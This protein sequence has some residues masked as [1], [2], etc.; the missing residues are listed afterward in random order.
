MF[1]WQNSNKSEKTG[2]SI[3]KGGRSSPSCIALKSVFLENVIRFVCIIADAQYGVSP[4]ALDDRFVQLVYLALIVG[5]VEIRLIVDAVLE[6][7]LDVAS[8][9]GVLALDH[10][11]LTGSRAR[12]RVCDAGLHIV[13]LDEVDRRNQVGG[14]LA[15]RVGGDGRKQLLGELR[16]VNDNVLAA[17][18]AT[19][20]E[21]EREESGADHCCKFFHNM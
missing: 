18:S 17:A 21:G 5:G 11:Y 10:G 7:L 12:A 16:G 4:G 19:G 1:I 13:S 6:K 2:E 20:C 8:F 14:G 9:G 15:Q 3:M